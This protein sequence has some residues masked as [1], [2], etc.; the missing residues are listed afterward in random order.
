MKRIE[1][2]IESIILA[3]RWLLVVFYLGL[4]IAL[5]IYAFS[6]AGKLVDFVTKIMV[7][8]ET[9]TILKM[10]SLID[11]ALVASLVVMVIISGY[12]NFVSQFDEADQV[13][14]LGTIDAGSLKIKVASTIV[15]ISS[16]HLLQ[17]FLNLVQYNTGQL[18]WFTII[19]LAFVFSALFLAYIDKLMVKDKGKKTSEPSL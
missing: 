19:H 7:M 10:L 3:S 15:A 17:V 16:I 11:A 1:I 12:E 5:A 14:W 4:A 13:H 6:F 9:D 18:T 2:L 8:N